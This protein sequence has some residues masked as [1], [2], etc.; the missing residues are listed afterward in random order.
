MWGY[1]SRDVARMLD[2]PV[3]RVRGWVRM[4]FATPRRSPAGALRFSFQDLLLLRTA[5]ELARARIPPRRVRR[6]L[7]QL[8]ARLP[9]GRPLA[10][11]RIAADGDQ[12][13]V[14]DG[15]GHW[16]PESGQALFDFAVSAVGQQVAPLLREAARAVDASG[17]DAQAWYTW[18]CD[19]ADGAPAQ[20]RKA[21]ARA[22]TLDPDHPGAN[23]AL[24]HLLHEEGDAAAAEGHYRRFLEARP[25]DSGAMFDLGVALEDQGRAD[26]ALLAHA[27]CLE[28]DPRHAEAHRR[29]AALLERLGR[30]PEARRHRAASRRLTGPG[31]VR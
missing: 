3:E 9:A 24:G 5:R 7:Q 15:G 28:S 21:W 29:A 30:G 20:A 1:S 19:L 14:R 27:R 31:K 6:A 10:S 22:L 8:R 12:L 26:E 18:G 11:V 13:V 16:R 25:A 4:G 23:R 17:L 2:L